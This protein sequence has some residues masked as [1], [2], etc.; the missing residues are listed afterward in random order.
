[1]YKRQILADIIYSLN[2]F[3]GNKYDCCG[4]IR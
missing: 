1:V 3:G 4:V 2:L